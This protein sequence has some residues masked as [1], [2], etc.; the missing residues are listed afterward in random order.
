M[1]ERPKNSMFGILSWMK[2]H[3]SVGSASLDELAAQFDV[4][5]DQ[6]RGQLQ[7]LQRDECVKRGGRGNAEWSIT[8]HG[9]LRLADG[10]FS[11]SGAFLSRFDP[12]GRSS[13]KSP[14]QARPAT[15]ITVPIASERGMPD[16]P[17]A[18]LSPSPAPW[19][20]PMGLF[21]TASPDRLPGWGT[22]RELKG[23][24]R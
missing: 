3:Q 12:T 4:T 23:S 5:R 18:R 15:M 13:E 8:D 2:E 19:A 1:P 6:M 10:R 22:T 11:P 9:L 7:T 20:G 16:A 21:R 14:D 17:D 24:A